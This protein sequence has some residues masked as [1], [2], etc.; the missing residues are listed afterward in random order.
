MAFAVGTMVGGGVFTL[1][2]TAV[3][4]AGPSAILCYALAGLILLVSALSFVAVAGRASVG[5]SG[6]GPISTILGPVWRFL[7]MW[8]FYVNGVTILT[9]LLVSFG[10]YLH[11]YFRGG[12]GPISAALIALV[13]VAILNLGPTD[14]VGKAEM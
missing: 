12:L 8:W 10:E 11:E 6:Y 4:E 3:N 9:F 14:L 1:S 7:V 13:A 5:D 2:G